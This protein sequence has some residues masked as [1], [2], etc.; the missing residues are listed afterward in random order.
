MLV[1]QFSRGENFEAVRAAAVLGEGMGIVDV[2]FEL[3]EEGKG[4]V[5]LTTLVRFS[6]HVGLKQEQ[7][8]SQTEILNA[9][10]L[11]HFDVSGYNFV[12]H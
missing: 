9:L 12:H 5:A 4:E 2:G 10:L 7:D 8:Q 3:S 1:Q 11:L 6:S